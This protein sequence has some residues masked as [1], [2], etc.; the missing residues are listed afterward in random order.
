MSQ[1]ENGTSQRTTAELAVMQ[2]LSTLRARVQ[3]HP[4]QTL[5]LAAALGLVGGARFWRR[6][7]APLLGAGARIAIAAVVPTLIDEIHS[8]HQEAR[9]GHSPGF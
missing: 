6:L 3:E 7:A 4:Y 1:P 8:K 9:D 5:G 2:V